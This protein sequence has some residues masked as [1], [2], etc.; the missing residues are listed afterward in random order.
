[1]FDYYGLSQR[2]AAERLSPWEHVGGGGIGYE[3][4]GDKYNST[5]L[6][7]REGLGEG[8]RRKVTAKSSGWR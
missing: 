4:V 8:R 2:V 1:M 3:N 5:P 6:P 7:G